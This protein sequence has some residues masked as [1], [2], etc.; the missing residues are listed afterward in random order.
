MYV[1]DDGECAEEGTWTLGERNN[2]RE[3]KNT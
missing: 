1:E 3:K 2:M